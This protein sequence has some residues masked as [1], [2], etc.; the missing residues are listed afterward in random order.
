M[1][2]RR[3]SAGGYIVLDDEEIGEEKNVAE[4]G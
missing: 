3:G 4:E 1:C 2:D